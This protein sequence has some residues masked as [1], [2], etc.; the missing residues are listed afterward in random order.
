MVCLKT[1]PLEAIDVLLLLSAKN[2]FCF[3]NLLV[4]VSS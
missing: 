1:F 2:K 3:Q 4:Y